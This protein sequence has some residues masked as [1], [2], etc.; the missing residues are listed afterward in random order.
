MPQSPACNSSSD[1]PADPTKLDAAASLACDDFA[2]DYKAADTRQERLDLA[3][4]VNK[5]APDSKTN[6]IADGGKVLAA[7]GGRPWRRGER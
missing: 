7:A 1:K 4:E 2:H 6:G 5:W 3:H